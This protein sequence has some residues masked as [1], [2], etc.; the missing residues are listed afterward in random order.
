MELEPFSVTVFGFLLKDPIV[1]QRGRD[2]QWAG[3]VGAAWSKDEN[4]GI[5]LF[6]D[7]YIV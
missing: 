5:D 1:K 4:P 3:T 6:I 7:L 2:G